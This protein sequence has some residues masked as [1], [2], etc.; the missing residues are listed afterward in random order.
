[1]IDQAASGPLPRDH[2]VRGR[3]W[4]LAAGCYA[5]ALAAAL[6]AFHET[7]VGLVGIWARSDTFGH[8][9]LIPLISA[10]LVWRRRHRLAAIT[11]RPSAVGLVAVAGLSAVWFVAR[12]GGVAVVE[13]FAFVGIVQALVLAIMGWRVVWALLFPLFFLIFM[14]PFGEFLIPPL[15]EVTADFVVWWLQL[16]GIP[17]FRDGIFLYIPSGAFEVAEACAGLRFLIAMVVLGLL[18]ANVTYTQWWRR[19]VFLLLAV[20]IPIVANGFRALMIVLIAHWSDHTLAVGVDHIVFGWVFLTFVMVLVLGA[21]MLLRERGGDDEDT[22]PAPPPRRPASRTAL[23]ASTVAAVA[24]LLTGPVYAMWRQA[25]PPGPAAIDL[26]LPEHADGWTLRGPASGAWRPVF[27]G[28]DRE[29]LVAYDDGETT[30]D[31]YIGY[32]RF[33]RQN[34]EVVNM[35]NTLFQPPPPEHLALDELVRPAPPWARVTDH[36]MQMVVDGR[37]LALRATQILSDRG[38]RRLVLPLYWVNGEIT[39]SRLE[40]KLLQVTAVLTGGSEAAAAIVL[41]APFTEDPAEAAATLRAFAAALP[42]VR[43]ALSA[44]AESF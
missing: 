20:S 28:A 31:V 30:V 22:G 29:D 10:F 34:A 27:H 33:Q 37:P 24:L 36:S 23:A 43:D 21:G 42:A 19:A 1:M 9:F 41:A 2:A 7:V 40:A 13:Q 25:H 18:F 4:P 17:I 38:E 12:L 26:A 35:T 8:G 3:E 16:I 5:V 44:A 11:P 15:Q 6:V 32:Y 14:V 39:Q